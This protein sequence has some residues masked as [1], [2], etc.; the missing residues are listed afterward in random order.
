M[1]A[2]NKT[3]AMRDMCSPRPRTRLPAEDN[4]KKQ[5][6]AGC[7]WLVGLFV[8]VVSCNAFTGN[9][10]EETDSPKTALEII[11]EDCHRDHAAVYDSDPL[12]L[13]GGELVTVKRAV[14]G[15]T[16]K[17]DDGRLVR[18]LGIN[19]PEPDQCA[20][21]GATEYARSRVEGRRVKLFQEPGVDKA[22]DEFLR[23]VRY[24][25]PE[26]RGSA[27]LFTE[28]LGSDTAS[29]GWAKAFENGANDSYD[30]H[31]ASSVEFASYRSQGINAPP[32]GKPKVRGDDNGN[33]TPDREE[34]VNVNG[35]NVHLRDGA[36]TGG[37]CRGKWY[38]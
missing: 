3:S 26:Y 5:T 37:H 7:L 21:A 10:S 24:P 4:V 32:C 28:D 6:G 18:L 38:C 35:P 17:L 9:D 29:E 8:V 27:T 23:Y 12:C 20:D 36:L 19:A 11:D 13:K 33:G 1:T 15:D 31:I 16:P 2:C 30:S 22:E 34:H 25:D 14:D